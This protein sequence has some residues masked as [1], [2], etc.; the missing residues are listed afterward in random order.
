[1]L[2]QEGGETPQDGREMWGGNP[3][4]LPD[5]ARIDETDLSAR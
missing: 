2:A 1:M 3:R 4:R 5:W